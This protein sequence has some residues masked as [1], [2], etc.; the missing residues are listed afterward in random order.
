MKIRSVFCVVFLLLACAANAQEDGSAFTPEQI[1]EMLPLKQSISTIQ[2]LVEAGFVESTVLEPATGR[3]LSLASDIA[4]RPVSLE[5]LMAVDGSLPELTGLQ[6]FAGFVTF[7]NI[8]WVLAIVIG[9]GSFCYLFADLVKHLFEILTAIP[10]LF[11]EFIFYG[12]S[13]GLI[14]Y[15]DSFRPGVG[16]YVALTGCLLFAGALGFTISRRD[17]TKGTGVGYFSILAVLY[18]GVA[19]L[20]SSSMIGFIAVGALMA[21]LGFSILVMPLCYCIGFDDE[22]SLGRAT[23]AAFGMLAVFT[24]ITIVGSETLSVFRPGALWLGSFVGYLGLLIASSRW[25]ERKFPYALMQ[26]VTIV[27]GVAALFVGSVWHIP[28]LQRIGGT[29]FV[30]YLLEKYIEIPARSARGYACMGLVGAGV[31]Y[32]FCLTVKS[33]PES[34]RPFLLF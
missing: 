9:V 30:L 27:A 12:L 34:W 10:L 8:M 29:F 26:V 3:Y 11:Y 33:N 22:D 17:L 7:M 14:L 4:G 32:W 18:A 13:L 6:K 1:G 25:Y 5:E 15:A 28:E 24:V 2:D 23:T 19:L 20:Y 21:A 31:V 16:H